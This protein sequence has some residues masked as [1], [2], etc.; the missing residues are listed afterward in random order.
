[1]VRRLSDFSHARFHGVRMHSSLSVGATGAARALARVVDFPISYL[2]SSLVICPLSSP[3]SFPLLVSSP[4]TRQLTFSPTVAHTTI[5]KMPSTNEIAIAVGV[6]LILAI[7]A[8]LAGNS[9]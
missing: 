3:S 9:E 4:S 6:I 1:M 2:I 5:P 7:V 8:Y